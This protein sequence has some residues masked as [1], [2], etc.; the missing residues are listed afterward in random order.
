MSQKRVGIFSGTFD[1]IHIGHLEAGLVARAACELTEVLVLVEKKPRRKSRVTSSS[2][3]A[4]MVKLATEDFQAIRLYDTDDSNIT[5][6]K[7]GQQLQRDFPGAVF[8]MIIGSDLLDHIVQ[9]AGFDTWIQRNEL[10]VVLRDNKDQSLVETKLKKLSSEVS[11][12]TYHLLPAVWSPLSSQQI[13]REIKK[14]GHTDAVHRN[15]LQYIHKHKL[16]GTTPQ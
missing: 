6:P 5:F 1:P 7:T 12:F 13:R 3:R 8:V 14:T 10:C 16:Y 15:V 2:D 4:A 11:R 9:W